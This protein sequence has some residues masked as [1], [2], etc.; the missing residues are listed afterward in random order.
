MLSDGGHHLAVVAAVHVGDLH[1]LTRG[2]LHV[3]KQ[4]FDVGALVFVG[5][6]WVVERSVAWMTR[7]R[8]LARDYERLSTTLAGLH[9]AAFAMLMLARFFGDNPWKG[10]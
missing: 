1:A 7:C 8:R 9:F 10:I 6:R 3:G 5:R 2:D 4:L